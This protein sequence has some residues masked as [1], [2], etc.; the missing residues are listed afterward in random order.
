MR[1]AAAPP[2]AAPTSALGASAPRPPPAPRT[3]TIQASADSTQG[4]LAQ[5]QEALAQRGEY[6]GYLQE[7]LGS[8][9]NGAAQFASETKKT[10]QREAAKTTM[11]GG[12]A[13]FFKGM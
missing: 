5:T 11:K 7:R 10:A 6:L 9:A 13:S 2:L 12:F 3:R 1:A 4:I 8:V